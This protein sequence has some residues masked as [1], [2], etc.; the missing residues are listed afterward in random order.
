VLGVAIAI[1]LHN[2][3]LKNLRLFIGYMSVAMQG[4]G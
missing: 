4:E 1:D 2:L 3:L